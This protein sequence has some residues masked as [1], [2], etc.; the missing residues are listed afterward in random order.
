MLLTEHKI[1]YR[2]TYPIENLKKGINNLDSVM[3]RIQVH[4]NPQ[5]LSDTQCMYCT[6]KIYLT[7]RY[8]ISLLNKNGV[9][10]ISSLNRENSN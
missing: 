9:R 8:T 5:G 4:V 6:C 1:E 3:I 7:L 2:L 10:L